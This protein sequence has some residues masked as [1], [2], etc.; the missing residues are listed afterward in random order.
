MAFSSSITV[1]GVPLQLALIRKPVKNVNAR[2]LGQ[3]LQVS[4]PP[5]LAEEDLTPLIT[6]LARRLLRRRRAR[7]V[8]GEGAAAE[9][10]RRMAAAFASPPPVKSVAFVT[11]QTQRWGSYSARTGTVRLNAAL[12]LMPRWVLEAVVA[13][14]LAHS[15]HPHH[16]ATF[17]TLLHQVHPAIDRANAFLAGVTWLARRWPTLPAVE[18]TLLAGVPPQQDPGDAPES[19]LAG[20]AGDGGER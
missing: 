2:L 10:V 14:E 7:E 6:A 11:S 19:Q 16:G 4:A 20:G 12:L 8:N 9:V 17:Q 5:H 13:H 3:C 1:D 18:K 15:F